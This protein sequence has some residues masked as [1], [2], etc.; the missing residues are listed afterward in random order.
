VTVYRLEVPLAH[1]TEA[2]RTL[3]GE[4][5]AFLAQEKEA[6]PDTFA[7]RGFDA[8]FSERLGTRGWLG[9]TIP[10]AYGGAGRSPVEQFVVAEE[11]LAARA[12]IGAHHAAE[13]QTAPML[14]RYGTEAQRRRFL[15]EIAAGRAGFALG[16]SEPDSGS[17]LASVR[18]RAT[19]DGSGWRVTGTKVWT[20]WADRVGHAVVLCRT[21]AEESKHAGLSQLIVDLRAPG[22]DVRPIRT[23]DGTA[24]FCEVILDDVVVP[25]DMVLG[26]IGDGWKQIGSELA[27]ERGGPD[28]WLSTFAVYAALVRAAPDLEPEA[29]V[30]IG[31]CAAW[32]RVLHALSY[33]IARAVAE[34][35]EPAVEAAAVKDLGTVF[36]QRVVSLAREFAADARPVPAPLVSELATAVR[37]FTLL[38]PG[39]TIRGGSTEILRTIV[40]REL[41]R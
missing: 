35:R 15:P 5:R 37:D 29:S 9:M 7:G 17:D 31:R 27:Y 14:L 10:C 24:H 30:A 22:V 8:G 34:G 33:G 41:L 16:M 26:N 19:P 36:E 20:S 18:T 6:D 40:S 21:S 23:L 2:E 13:R 25:A 1:E 32:Y 3:R 38:A 11:L 39:Y 12:P 28:R 4:V